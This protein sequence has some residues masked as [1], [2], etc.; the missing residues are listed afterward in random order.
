MVPVSGSAYAYSYA[1]LGEFVAWFVGWNLV[2]EYLFAAATVAVGWSRY[3]VKLLE[4]VNIH[5]PDTLTSAPFAAV[6]GSHHIVTNR[7]DRQSAGRADHARSSRASATSASSS[8]RCSTASSWRSRSP[9][10]CWSSRSARSTSTSVNWD[11]YIPPNTGV[12]G[13]FGLVGHP[14]RVGHHLLR[15]HRVRCGVD[16]GAGSEEPVARHADRHSRQ[17]GHLHAAVHPDVCGADGPRAVQDAQRCRAG[18][19]RPAGALWR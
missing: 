13:E 19:R 11:P 15:V 9:W 1:T 6:A 12:W 14:A 4:M 3:A 16:R 18:R 10:S 17:P 8:P 7:R 5:L 2:L